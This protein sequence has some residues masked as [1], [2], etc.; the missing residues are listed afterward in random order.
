MREK[1]METTRFFDIANAVNAGNASLDYAI[2]NNTQNVIAVSDSHGREYMIHINPVCFFENGAKIY[3]SK[4]AD[5]LN[6]GNAGFSS[7]DW[8]YGF[9]HIIIQDC[10]SLEYRLT[11]DLVTVRGS[12]DF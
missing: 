1:I 11:V 7:C 5:M 3:F 9:N 8:K 6:D 12:R 4:L 2:G 10:Y